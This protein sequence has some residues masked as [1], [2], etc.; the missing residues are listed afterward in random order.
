[1]SLLRSEEYTKTAN[2]LVHFDTINLHIQDLDINECSQL[3]QSL[4]EKINNF[5]LFTFNQKRNDKIRASLT[6]IR[7]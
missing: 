1:M 2:E 6:Q 7:S 5:P 3:S 4:F